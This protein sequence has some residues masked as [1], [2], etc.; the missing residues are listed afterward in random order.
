MLSKLNMVSTYELQSVNWFE[1]FGTWFS[2]LL[3]KKYVRFHLS[4]EVSK[5]NYINKTSLKTITY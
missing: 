1:R 3:L 4:L 2:Y 5:K